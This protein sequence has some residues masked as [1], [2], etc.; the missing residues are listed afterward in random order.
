[1]TVITQKRGKFKRRN[2]KEDTT[3][4]RRKKREKR[5]SQAK[6]TKRARGL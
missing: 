6:L 2:K 4:I 1:M 3:G 5:K